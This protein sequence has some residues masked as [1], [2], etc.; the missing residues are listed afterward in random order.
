MAGKIAWEDG[1]VAFPRETLLPAAQVFTDFWAKERLWKKKHGF[2]HS[3]TVI[4]L[5]QVQILTSVLKDAGK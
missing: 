3:N 4:Q 2:V 5:D 1:S